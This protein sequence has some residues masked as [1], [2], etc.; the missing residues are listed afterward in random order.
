MA[1]LNILSS[2]YVATV[3]KELLSQGKRQ[4]PILNTF[5][6]KTEY[7]DNGVVAVPKEVTR[8]DELLPLIKAGA[9]VPVEKL[10]YDG[11]WNYYALK[12][13]G[14]AK[15]I[16]PDE[17]E[18]F[19]RQLQNL[20][21][22]TYSAMKAQIITEKIQELINKALSTR[23]YMAGSALL[24]NIKDKDG[25]VLYTFDIPAA[26]KLGTKS[27]SDDTDKLSVVLYDL[28][29]VI[30]KSTRYTG[31]FGIIAGEG[32]Y[33][34]ILKSPSYQRIQERSLANASENAAGVVDY[35][36]KRPLLIA[37]SFYYDKTNTKKSFFNEDSIGLAP[38]SLFST[39]YTHIATNDGEFR[40]LDHID[41]Y[42]KK[43]PDGRVIRLQTSAMPLVTLANAI[44]TATLS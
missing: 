14:G 17:I 1:D 37:D 32:A 26:N 3:G 41:T 4:T 9:G 13:F 16:K 39:F 24:G 2:G 7:V 40:E 36:G 20:T 23:E 15:L 42:D 5:F 38:T 19:K 27:V 43:N 44:S 33:E 22:Q 31:Q 10:N 8:A 29:K 28:E 34:K 35:I 6:G 12:T 18:R 21:G 25:N 30:R 11:E